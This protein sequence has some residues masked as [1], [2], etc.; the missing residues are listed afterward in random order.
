MILQQ[1]REATAASHA[2]LESTLPLS[3]GQ[4]TRERYIQVLQDFYGFFAA[5][6]QEARLAAPAEWRPLLAERARTHLLERD[7]ATLH[8]PLPLELAGDLPSLHSTASLLGSMYVLEGSRLG[9][10]YLVRDLETR[11]GLTP[12]QGLSFFYGFGLET[13]SRWKAFCWLLESNVTS[14]MSAEVI[15][16]ARQTF[17]AFQRWILSC[18]ISH[19]A[20]ISVA[21]SAK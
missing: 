14:A 4:L 11:L 21:E 15:P 6:E 5:W 16:A 12:Q 8:A 1:L 9:G 17:A 13:G 7:L 20:C 10:Q 19:E 18:G 3:G 2:A